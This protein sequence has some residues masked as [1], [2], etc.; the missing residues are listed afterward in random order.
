MACRYYGFGLC[1]QLSYFFNLFIQV[2]LMS[3]V[4][5][6][7]V[8]NSSSSSFIIGVG[9]VTDANK[10][11][12]FIETLNKYDKGSCHI[13]PAEQIALHSHWEPVQLDTTSEITD[14]V[15]NVEYNNLKADVRLPIDSIFDEVFTVAIDNNEGDGQEDSDFYEACYGDKRPLTEDYLTSM[16]KNMALQTI[17]TKLVQIATANYTASKP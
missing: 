2:F 3:R 14:V 7:F 17:V 1:Y 5:L 9:R 6:G 10:A 12:K 11:Y 15:V 16:N 4:R 13:E 8:S